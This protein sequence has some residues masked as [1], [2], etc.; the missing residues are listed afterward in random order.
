MRY[1]KIP[2]TEDA[3]LPSPSPNNHLLQPPS[4]QII[5]PKPSASAPTYPSAAA[6]SLP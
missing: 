4:G 6:A 5:R 1:N 3:A 2:L